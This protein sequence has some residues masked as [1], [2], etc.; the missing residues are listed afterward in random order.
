[1]AINAVR[2][3]FASVTA[4]YM[5]SNIIDSNW[6]DVDTGLIDRIVSTNAFI[7]RAEIKAA[8]IRDLTAYDIVGG[9]LTATNNAS[10]WDLINGNFRMNDADFTLGGGAQIRLTD[11][12]NKIQFGY[13]SGIIRTAGMGVGVALGD[14]FPFSYLGTTGDDNLDTLNQYF[15]GFISNTTARIGEGGANSV[16]GYRFQIR[17]EAVDWN[18]GLDFD[19]NGSPTIRPYAHGTH[20]LGTWNYRFR[21]VYTDSVL[22]HPQV[23]I[24]NSTANR[25]FTIDTDYR[26]GRNPAI[27]GQ[28]PYE[29]DYDLGTDGRAFYWG[30][31]RELRPPRSG[32]GGVG[33]SDRPYAFGHINTLTVHQNFW[34]NSLREYKEN[35]HDLNLDDAIDFIRGNEIKV[36]NYKDSDEPSVGLIRDDLVGRDDLVANETAISPNNVQ[37]IAQKVLKHEMYRNDDQDAEIQGLKYR[38]KELEAKMT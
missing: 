22:G 16:S 27:Y 24:T 32:S 37:Y 11:R 12:N 19:L 14:E 28:Y 35:I 7:D 2:A 15:S 10:E 29:N 4:E 13:K 38:I 1:M 30:Y 3:D 5:S 34:N 23:Y 33:S 36:F 18:K 21:R 8:N 6:L 31:I 20:E 26:D 25:G 9:R 17:N